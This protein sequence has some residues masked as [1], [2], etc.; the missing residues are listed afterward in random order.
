[1]LI[2]AILVAFRPK[3]P[4]IPIKIMLFRPNFTQILLKSGE[5]HDISSYF[6]PI[7]PPTGHVF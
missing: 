2:I 4:S 1:M 5:N 7:P 3:I 6:L